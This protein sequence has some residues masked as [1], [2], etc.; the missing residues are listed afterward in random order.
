MSRTNPSATPKAA[1]SKGAAA[2][3]ATAAAKPAASKAPA[4]KPEPA[5]APPGFW[6]RRVG[7]Y[8]TWISLVARLYLGGMWLY[9]SI[10]KLT[11]PDANEI[12]VRAF[13]LLPENLVAPFAYIQPYLELSLGLLLIVGL[14]TRV[15]ALLSGLLLLVYIGG[16]ISLGARG[17]QIQCGCGGSGGAILPGAHTRYILDTLR[18]LGYL[19]FALWLLWKPDSKYSA[20]SVLLPPIE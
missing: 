4:K 11:S 9:Y 1:A 10:P 5:P 16:I 13:R 14:G 18:D 12:S 7:P 2:T 20:D 17:I 8:E 19:V 3:K 6:R 15:V